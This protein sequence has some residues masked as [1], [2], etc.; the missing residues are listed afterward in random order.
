MIDIHIHILPGLDDGPAEIAE[1]LEMAR[2]CVAQGV[3]AV[4]ATPH[5]VTG[6]YHNSRDNILEALQ[7]LRA[8]LR[9]Q[10]IPLEVHPGA[11]YML[12][13]DLPRL[14]EAGEAM[15]IN[16]GGRFILVEFPTLEVPFFVPQLFFELALLGVTPILAHPERNQ[17]LL[18]QPDL[19]APLL[20][21]GLL[22]QGT[23]GSF[24]GRFGPRVQ[25]L[26]HHYLQRGYYHYICSDAHGSARRKTHLHKFQDLFPS[27]APQLAETNPR[28]LLQGQPPLPVTEVPGAVP[29]GKESPW[30]RFW[31]RITQKK[32][33]LND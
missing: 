33:I 25:Q 24:T 15:T 19:L 20:Q 28:R 3:Q 16:D 26:A 12:D 30:R 7:Q 21:R 8:A 22:C 5:V 32:G 4:V 11:E 18:R 10:G 9:D 31:H 23:A 1:S 13:P 6:L 17:A 14:I 2:Q 29:G 27:V